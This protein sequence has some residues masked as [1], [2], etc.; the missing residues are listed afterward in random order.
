[1][2]LDCYGTV[3]F[4]GVRQVLVRKEGRAF[5]AD[6]NGADAMRTPSAYVG[7]QDEAA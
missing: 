2:L 3:G 1:M 6:I 5:A 4:Y 7:I